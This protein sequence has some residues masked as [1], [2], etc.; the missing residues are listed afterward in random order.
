MSDLIGALRSEQC[1]P[2]TGCRPQSCVCGLMDDAADEI[3]RL[4][5]QAQSTALDYLAL[6]G[7]ASEAI[8]RATAAEAEAERLRAALAFLRPSEWEQGDICGITFDARWLA[9]HIDAALER[10]P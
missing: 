8:A 5:S 3:E 1:E 4:Q 2:N 7:Q 9:E 10:K 6:D